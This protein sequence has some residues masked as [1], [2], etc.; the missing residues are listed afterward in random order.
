M[1]STVTLDEPV[2]RVAGAGNERVARL[3]QLLEDPDRDLR[4]ALALLALTD[5]VARAAAG[6]LR[7]LAEED[8]YSGPHANLV[9]LP[10]LQPIRSRFNDATF[11]AWY[12]ATDAKTAYEE[13]AFHLARWLA[14]SAG[15]PYDLRQFVVL[16]SITDPLH[17][18]RRGEP[19]VSEDVYNPD[20]DRYDAA[21]AL[22]RERIAAGARGLYYDSV[23]RP[24][25]LCCAIYRPVAITNVDV[26]EEL[27]LEWDGTQLRGFRAI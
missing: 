23:R 3:A 26:R 18:V 16:A 7:S 17:D 14:R 6:M 12:A 11:G 4:D 24:G 13:R 19:G 5:K 27:H 15:A 22:A 1:V 2:T 21:N 8:R 9:M 10:F 25:G 20:P